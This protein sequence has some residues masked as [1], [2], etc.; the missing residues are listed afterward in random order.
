MGYRNDLLD[1]KAYRAEVHPG[2]WAVIPPTG[3]VNNV[4]PYI[5]GCKVSIVASPKMG[6][7]FVQ[8]VVEAGEGAKTTDYFGKAS[9]EESF[10]YIVEGEVKVIIGETEYAM[11][12]GGYGFAPAG[13]G[14]QFA[15]QGDAAKILLYKQRYIPL[16]GHE[17]YAVTGNVNEMEFIPYDGM[18]N[19][20]IKD[21][22]PAELG[23]DMNMHILSFDPGAS[24]SIVETHVQEHGMYI[25]QGEGMY[26]LDDTWMGIRKDDFVWFGAYCP[27][28]SYGV[29]KEPFAYIYSKDCNRD[30]EI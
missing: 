11:S 23:F 24:H 14:I 15:N 25:L 19:V 29:G 12:A 8:Y 30:V 5:E 4:I 13:L 16:E 22:L 2:L 7:G 6:A 9:H 3:V 1:V 10:I 27:Q 18:D 26:L 20:F 17:P 21:L 28:C